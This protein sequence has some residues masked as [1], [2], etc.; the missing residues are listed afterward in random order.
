LNYKNNSGETPL[1][2]LP[3]DSEMAKYLKEH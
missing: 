1:S 3:P 2:L